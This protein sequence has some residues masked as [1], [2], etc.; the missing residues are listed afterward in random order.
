MEDL[1]NRLKEIIN[2]PIVQFSNHCEEISHLHLEQ[3]LNIINGNE[4]FDK[5][6]AFSFLKQSIKFNPD[7]KKT[8]EIM[9]EKILGPNSSLGDYL[10]VSKYVPDD[11]DI[12]LNIG[13]IYRVYKKF[14]ESL[15]YLYKCFSLAEKDSEKE[16]IYL[17]F[18][19]YYFSLEEHKLS[20]YYALLSL[21]FNTYNIETLNLLGCICVYSGLSELAIEFFKKCLRLKPN[22]AMFCLNIGLPYAQLQ[23]FETSR[24]YYKKCLEMD[25]KCYLAYQ[26]I[27]LD[28]NYDP[29]LSP[30]NRFEIHKQIDNYLDIKN[31]VKNK[32]T[33]GKV[34]ILTGDLINH[35]VLY[36]IKT[37]I[38]KMEDLVIFANCNYTNNKRKVINVENFSPDDFK[39]VVEQE[40]IGILIDLSV[41]TGKNKIRF[42]EGLSCTIINYLGYPSTS[43]SKLYDYRLVDKITDENSLMTEKPLFFKDSF[44]CYNYSHI[45]DFKL[46]TPI[47]KV[48]GCFS[49][50]QKINKK[51]LSLYRKVLV[52][53][54]DCIIVFKNK[55]IANPSNRKF[56][57]DYIP[58]N[59]CRFVNSIEDK[60]KAFK[61]YNN[62]SILLDTFPYNGTCTT[63]D[64]LA[65]GV[66]VLTMKGDSHV[67]RVSQSI[68]VNS[69]LTEWVAKNEADFIEKS[70]DLIVNKQEVQKKFREGV[71]CCKDIWY[72]DFCNIIDSIRNTSSSYVL[73]GNL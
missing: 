63:A 49:R 55:E 41:H 59:R 2:L 3:A 7:N 20:F 8:K 71:V 37:L 22:D 44:L 43:G 19:Q 45:P 27:C 54:P 64:S 39:K 23:D 18:A 35:P 14:E 29:N 56:I 66:P 70:R 60:D 51:V 9:K 11:F 21:K 26:N 46:E 40:N 69:N 25:P 28:S 13:K 42:L 62:I 10:E 24:Q 38:D 1:N 16:Q 33:T 73:Q 72:D 53:N 61:F 12:L 4:S 36:F 31:L 65:C 5:A 6:L 17:E 67:S 15:S 48:F 34:A 47:N 57:L 50:M 58:E 30:Q 32:K 52:A 68:L